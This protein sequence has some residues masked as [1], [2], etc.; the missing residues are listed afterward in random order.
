[1]GGK[2]LRCSPGFVGCCMSS[3]WCVWYVTVSGQ[4][5]FDQFGLAGFV[6]DLVGSLFVLVNLLSIADGLMM[7]H[8]FAAVLQTIDQSSDN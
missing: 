4:S 7:F 3:V 2:L 8:S 6:G 5:R 1:M